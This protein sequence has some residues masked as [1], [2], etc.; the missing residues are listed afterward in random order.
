ML[1]VAVLFI[2]HQPRGD[3]IG[4]Q[5]PRLPE[6]ANA[7]PKVSA[8][9]SATASLGARAQPKFPAAAEIRASPDARAAYEKYKAVADPTGEIAY[10]LSNLV[11]RC[12]EFVDA[13]LLADLRS[14]SSKGANPARDSLI[15]SMV[16][17]CKGFGGWD[18]NQMVDAVM[19]LRAHA[20]EARFPPAIASSLAAEF[21]PQTRNQSDE[22]A[23]ALLNEGYVDGE[24]I[25]GVY[26]YLYRRN[27]GVVPSG[28]GVDPR[29][30]DAAWTLVQCNYG[31]DCD[32]SNYLVSFMCLY[33][34]VCTT[35]VEAALRARYPTLTAADWREVARMESMIG[36]EIRDG[37]WTRLGF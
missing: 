37:D 36:S 31:S 1:V 6:A 15:D 3:E 8:I 9:R 10:S 32:S 16:D 28:V 19:A 33:D 13:T 35:D 30:M 22:T 17:R 5:T 27:D 23:K 20:L 21:T 4:G 14:R 12:I 34:G 18:Q 25:R 29:L 7:P 26:A 11:G 24:V 2:Y